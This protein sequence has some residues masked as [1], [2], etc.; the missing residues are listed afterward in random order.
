MQAILRL[1]IG[2][3]SRSP[4][5]QSMLKAIPHELVSRELPG[6]INVDFSHL[7]LGGRLDPGEVQA[8]KY[9]C[10]LVS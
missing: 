2:R 5:I 10:E 9:F 4:S 1:E 6:P 3:F 8:G 7:G